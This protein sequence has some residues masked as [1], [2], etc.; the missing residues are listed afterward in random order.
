MGCL[1]SESVQGEG[2][3]PS[4]RAGTTESVARMRLAL[5]Q[6]IRKMS[7]TVTSGLSAPARCACS[8]YHVLRAT[9][10]LEARIVEARAG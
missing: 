6:K 2:E 8:R 3:A 10:E 7:W 1:G 5:D 4:P 9:R